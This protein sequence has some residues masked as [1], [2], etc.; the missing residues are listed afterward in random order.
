[1]INKELRKLIENKLAMIDLV[2]K[3]HEGNSNGSKFMNELYGIKQALSTLG[4]TLTISINPYFYEDGEKST[5][6]VE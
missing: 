5:Y 6:T 2:N 3:A 1:M 4:I